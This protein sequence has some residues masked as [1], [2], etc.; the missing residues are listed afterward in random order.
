MSYESDRID[1]DFRIKICLFAIA[2]LFPIILAVF[3]YINERGDGRLK[4][5]EL[6]NGKVVECRNVFVG[7]GYSYLKE[8]L[9]KN[10]YYNIPF[11]IKKEPTP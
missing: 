10:E 2:M 5:I 6:S 1:S 9:D 8:C 4:L 11:T 7:N 3:L